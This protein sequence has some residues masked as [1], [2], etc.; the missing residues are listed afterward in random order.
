MA[1]SLPV[2]WDYYEYSRDV[3]RALESSLQLWI[4]E[5]DH[6]KSNVITLEL[7]R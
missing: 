7:E 3:I 4:I 5:L 6:N 1:A 2:L